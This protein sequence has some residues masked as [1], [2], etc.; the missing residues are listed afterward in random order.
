LDQNFLPSPPRRSFLTRLNTVFASLAAMAGVAMAQQKPLDKVS[1]WEPARHDQ[2]DWMDNK[3]AKHRVVFDTTVSEALSDASAFASNFYHANQNDYGIENSD[4]AVMI[5]LRHRTAQFGFNDAIWAKYGEP[6]ATRAKIED[7]K[8]RQA[9]KVNLFNV[10][11][12][13]DSALNKGM[14]L[15]ALAKLGVQFAVCRLSTRAFAGAIAKAT[16]GKSEEILA[17]LSANLI[18]N[19]RLVPAGIVA[20]NR[21]QE[22]GYT[23]MSV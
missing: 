5:V 13:G 19:A 6:I 21:A 22:R 23:L 2:D 8:T 14:T 15:E 7:P 3:R 4:L 12:G 9:P 11:G 18:T 10:T 17:E 1:Q 20:V 16:G